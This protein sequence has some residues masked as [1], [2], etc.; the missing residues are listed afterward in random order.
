MPPAKRRRRSSSPSS[1]LS[2][3]S[4]SPSS[5]RRRPPKHA[6]A[7]SPAGA[8]RRHSHSHSARERATPRRGRHEYSALSRAELERRLAEREGVDGGASEDDDDVDNE[9]R[10]GRVVADKALQLGNDIDEA[11][12]N[13]HRDARTDLRAALDG[14]RVV[15]EAG[16]KAFTGESIKR[17]LEIMRAS[18]VDKATK[19]RAAYDDIMGVLQ[20]D[21]AKVQDLLARYEEGMAARRRVVDQLKADVTA[22]QTRHREELRSMQDELGEEE[23]ASIKELVGIPAKAATAIRRKLHKKIK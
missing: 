9:T 12:H 5:R 14:I 10:E 1:S 19:L 22:A 17:Q 8:G 6:G 20:A 21:D 4:S 2:S 7:F 23:A 15:A 3:L 13:F 11:F 18:Q 16:F